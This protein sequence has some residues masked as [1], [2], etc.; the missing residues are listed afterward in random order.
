VGVATLLLLL[1]LAGHRAGWTSAPRLQTFAAMFPPM[2]RAPQ[3]AT[4]EGGSTTAR[5][6][7]WRPS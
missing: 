2:P 3:G 5:A 6:A 1:F 7:G 4:R